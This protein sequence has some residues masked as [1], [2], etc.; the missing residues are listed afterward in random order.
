MFI[1]RC[2][3][4][5]H[6]NARKHHLIVH[7]GSL[8]C[9]AGVWLVLGDTWATAAAVNFLMCAIDVIVVFISL[10]AIVTT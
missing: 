8:S 6:F 1:A 10:G 2:I 3:A 4:V 7:K 9:V 5:S